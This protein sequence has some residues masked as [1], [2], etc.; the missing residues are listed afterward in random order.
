LQLVGNGFERIWSKLFF[1]V[2]PAGA[3]R[4]IQLTARERQIIS[5]V[6]EGLS[7]KEIAQRINLAEGTI[8]LHLH[9]IYEKLETP[10]RTA[11][12]ALAIAFQHHLKLATSH[13][14]SGA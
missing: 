10:N 13:D 3:P 11:L 9:T 5:L 1:A 8:K 7:N 6:A 14:S 4:V 2:T 12:T